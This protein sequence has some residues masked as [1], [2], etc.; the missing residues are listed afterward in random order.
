MLARSHLNR[1]KRGEG[2]APDLRSYWK[3]FKG[4]PLQF[5]VLA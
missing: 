3:C 1:K 5:T 2:G 4:K